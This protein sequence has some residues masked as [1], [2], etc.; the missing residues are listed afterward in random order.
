MRGE[1]EP[2][3][4]LPGFK[5]RLAEEALEDV[6]NLNAASQLVQAALCQLRT[7]DKH[8]GTKANKLAIRLPGLLCKVVNLPDKCMPYKINTGRYFPTAG[9]VVG[10][11]RHRVGLSPHPLCPGFHFCMLDVYFPMLAIFFFS[12]ALSSRSWPDV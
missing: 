1:W 11:G 10:W 6:F 4:D 8:A 3:L 2:V 9:R 7:V 5:A 12:P